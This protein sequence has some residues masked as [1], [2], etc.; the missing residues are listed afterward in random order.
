MAY[1]ITERCSGC[2]LCAEACVVDAVVE[3]RG[4]PF[5]IDQDRCVLCGE[6]VTACPLDAIEEVARPTEREAAAASGGA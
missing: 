4:L 1:R 6:C 5:L 2:G 3:D